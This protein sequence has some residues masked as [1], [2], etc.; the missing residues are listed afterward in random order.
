MTRI[1][2]RSEDGAFCVKRS[3][4]EKKKVY[5]LKVW[6]ADDST[7]FSKQEDIKEA[8]EKERE[9]THK[10]NL[11]AGTDDDEDSIERGLTEAEK[12]DR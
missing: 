9:R 10:A 7:K 4:H 8:V 2:F 6:E 5:S 12:M 11:L 1:P 3:L